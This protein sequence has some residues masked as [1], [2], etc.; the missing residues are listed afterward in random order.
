ML[1]ASLKVSAVCARVI[2]GTSQPS[3]PQGA[4]RMQLLVE[5]PGQSCRLSDRIAASG[6]N[7]LQACMDDDGEL[8]RLRAS[9]RQ[10]TCVAMS[11]HVPAWVAVTWHAL[12]SHYVCLPPDSAPIQCCSA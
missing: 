2:S 8:G 11:Q 7:G 3:K 9:E 1:T 12:M 6:T 5:A 4:Q 10:Q